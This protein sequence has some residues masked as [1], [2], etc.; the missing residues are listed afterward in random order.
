MG[1]RALLRATVVGSI[2]GLVVAVSACRTFELP[3]ETC[4]GSAINGRTTAPGSS[5]LDPT[6]S[7]CVED[8]CCDDVGRCEAEG[9]CSETVSKAHACV[10]ADP[11]RAA[12]RESSCTQGLVPGSR[13]AYAYACMRQKCGGQCALPVCEVDPS[14]SLIVTSSCDKCIAGACCGQLNACYGNRTCKL[15]FECIVTHCPADVAKSPGALDVATSTACSGHPAMPEG[16]V[17]SCVAQC[18]AEFSTHPQGAPTDPSE[19]AS[20]LAAKTYACATGAGCAAA[21]SPDGG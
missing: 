18:F 19:E 4:H 14:A 15:T 17:S 6:C 11:A 8:A 21:C 7:R 9:G 16:A 3:S 10:L 5:D 1:V 12:E 13:A 20:C 2:V